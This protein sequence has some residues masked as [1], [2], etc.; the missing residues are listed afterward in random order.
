MNHRLV[1]WLTAGALLV[2]FTVS[3]SVAVAAN[4]DDDEPLTGTTLEQA[5]DAALAET[6]GGTVLET[7]KGDDGTAYSVEVQT[8]DGSVVEVN[9]DDQFTVIGSSTDDDAGDESETTGDD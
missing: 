8:P 7:E 5:S 9:L 6:G 4:V 2:A 3:A 1:G